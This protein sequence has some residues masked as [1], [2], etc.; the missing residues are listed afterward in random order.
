MRTELSS[1]LGQFLN[2]AYHWFR[3]YWWWIPHDLMT[4][5]DQDFCFS[6]FSL[7]FSRPPN[8]TS[9][10]LRVVMIS[11]QGVAL[12]VQDSDSRS[13]VFQIGGRCHNY[14]TNVIWREIQIGGTICMGFIHSTK[15]A[16][17]KSLV[18]VHS[19]ANRP[20]ICFISPWICIC[21]G[22]IGPAEWT[23]YWTTESSNENVL[24][25]M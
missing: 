23:V 18:R 6:L 22:R 1:F 17:T 16:W 21:C 7:P 13:S 19:A 12:R 14:C 11:G 8:P 25:V 2:W 5:L 4:K 10:S 20:L 24:H 9:S 3:V 15:K